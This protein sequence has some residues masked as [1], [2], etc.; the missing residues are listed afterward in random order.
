MC[1]FRI[2][3]RSPSRIELRQGLG[4]SWSTWVGVELGDGGECEAR[5]KACTVVKCAPMKQRH[6]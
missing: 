1:I 5:K 6:L 4:N 3:V 2:F